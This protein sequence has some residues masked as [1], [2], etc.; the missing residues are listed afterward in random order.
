MEFLLMFFHE[1]K[2]LIEFHGFDSDGELVFF[3]ILDIMYS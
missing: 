2:K 3:F 1:W